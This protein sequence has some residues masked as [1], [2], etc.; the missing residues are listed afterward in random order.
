MKKYNSPAFKVI[1]EQAVDLYKDGL[2]SA[3]E[4]R[5]FDKSCLVSGADASPSTS[6]KRPPLAVSAV[7]S[8][9]HGRGIK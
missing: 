3:D 4:M 5:D 2:I 9:A 6:G 8:H 1:Y 7:G